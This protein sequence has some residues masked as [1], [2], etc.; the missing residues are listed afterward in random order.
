LVDLPARRDVS[1]WRQSVGVDVKEGVII[2]VSNH[3]LM[4]EGRVLHVNVRMLQ[5]QSI[6]E[7]NLEMLVI[8]EDNLRHRFH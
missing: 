5:R 6:L 2:E 8:K 7:P 4:N 3:V 1:Q